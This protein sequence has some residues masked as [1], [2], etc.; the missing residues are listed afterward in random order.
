MSQTA[1]V[2]P[3]IRY[4]LET[5]ERLILASELRVEI[6]REPGQALG[7]FL[8]GVRIEHIPTGETVACSRH[9]SQVE[10]KLHALLELRLRL[11]QLHEPARD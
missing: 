8:P 4:L 3:S 5:A 11:D 6:A 9:S 1:A 10:N 2:P 7:E